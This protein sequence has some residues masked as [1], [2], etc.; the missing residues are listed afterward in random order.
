MGGT[1][2]LKNET[3]GVKTCT[4]KRHNTC[5]KLAMIKRYIVIPVLLLVTACNQQPGAYAGDTN[6]DTT[7]AD[8]NKAVVLTTHDTSAQI[9]AGKRIG[10]ISIGEPMEDLIAA[11]GKPDSSDAGMGALQFT[12]YATDHKQGYRTDV[13]GHAN[14]NGKDDNIRP[15]ILISVNSPLFKTSEGFGAGTNYGTIKGQH[16]LTHVASYPATATNIF[17]DVAGGIAFEVDKNDKCVAVLVH[18]P[19]DSVASRISLKPGPEA[20]SR[21]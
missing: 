2:K 1:G 4:V 9:I 18:A 12:W 17:D 6:K 8:S 13:Y 16:T 11:L 21:R 5:T 19:G 20:V 7:V 3:T 14:F 15:V 10:H